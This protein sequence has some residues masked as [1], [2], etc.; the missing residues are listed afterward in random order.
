MESRDDNFSDST[1]DDSN[2]TSFESESKEAGSNFRMTSNPRPQGLSTPASTHNPIVN[3]QCFHA[4][5]KCVDV[6]EG[7]DEEDDYLIINIKPKDSSSGKD[8]SGQQGSNTGTALT[9]TS[10][11][12]PL[13][14]VTV[15]TGG[16]S[17]LDTSLQKVSVDIENVSTTLKTPRGFSKTDGNGENNLE[18]EESDDYFT[19]NIKT[20]NDDELANLSLH[21]TQATAREVS[22]STWTPLAP[23]TVSTPIVPHTTRGSNDD[24]AASTPESIY[25]N[26]FSKGPQLTSTP[27]SALTT[28]LSD[29]DTKDVSNSQEDET[30]ESQEDSEDYLIININL[31]TGFRTSKA[32]MPDAAFTRATLD[33]SLATP[34]TETSPTSSTPENIFLMGKTEDPFSI[35]T[36]G[37]DISISTVK[38]SRSTVTVGHDI[39]L[40]TSEELSSDPGET[41]EYEYSESQ[42]ESEDYLI[43]NVKRPSDKQANE[44]AIRSA[45]TTKVKN[46]TKEAGVSTSSTLSS[47]VKL[48]TVPST[49]VKPSTIPST[50][51]TPSMVP[52]KRVEP[53]TGRSTNVRLPRQ[54]QNNYRP[55]RQTGRSMGRY[56]SVLQKAMRS[57]RDRLFGG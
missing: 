48:S 16:K 45:L 15:S 49:P 19:V 37:T 57:V 18:N 9:I 1:I 5:Q 29:D 3:F 43:I 17:D 40:S 47:A 53:S 12:S 7:L 22:P 14:E 41:E 25:E 55:P 34:T 39:S 6:V 4:C 42:E 28:V 36:P 51:L 11:A 30:W 52:F 32:P 26:L 21:A 38:V 44:R 13:S 27:E 24:T 46:S 20:K 2:E 10:T 54:N 50:E 33:S 8:E 31:P 23:L 56:E 35:S